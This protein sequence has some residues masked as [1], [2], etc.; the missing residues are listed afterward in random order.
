MEQFGLPSV[1]VSATD[2]VAHLSAR[3]GRY[4]ALPGGE[5]TA[6]VFKLV[7]ADLRADLRALVHAARQQ[8]QATRSA[9]IEVTLEGAAR[10]V[11]LHARPVTEPGWEGL[12][13]VLFEEHAARDEA[14][15]AASPAAQA[16]GGVEM[17]GDLRET[18]RRLQSI[19]EESES[20][21]ERMAIWNEELQSSNEELRSTTEELETSKEE[22]Q[23]VNEE[24]QTI[25]QENRLRLAE[26][27][28][29]SGDLQNLLT[30]TDIATLFL[31]RELRVMRFTPPATEL[32][33]VRPVD[34]G[35]PLS[36]IR[37]GLDYAELG[38][39]A[40]GVL[41]TLAPSER[42]VEGE[43]RWYLAR[44]LPYRTPEDH[45]EGVVVT[46]LDIT[47]RK[48]ADRAVRE[49]E[50]RFRTLAETVPDAVF[51]ATADGAVDYVNGAY[52]VLTGIDGDEVLGTVAW[53]GL[54]HPEDRDAA[55]AAWG[56][57]LAERAPFEAR[58]RLR[59]TASG[60][61]GYRW[62]I[63]RAR[64]VLDD[65]GAPA[66]WFGAITDVDALARA[67]GALRTLAGTLEER[68][69]TRTRQVRQLSSSLVEAERDERRRIA[70]VLH[71]NLQQLL[72]SIQLKVDSTRE[73]SGDAEAVEAQLA[74]VTAWLLESI[75]LTRTLTSDLAPLALS[76]EGV[77]AELAEHMREFHGLQV[78]VVAEGRVPELGRDVGL[79]AARALRELLFNVARHAGTDQATVHVRSSEDRLGV[80]VAD[81]GLGF[82][83]DE[84]GALV[85]GTGLGL[86]GLRE[87]VE[88]FGG[89]MAIESAPG[90]GTR[91][92]ISVPLP[93]A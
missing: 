72:N 23:S 66:R 1:L 51:T 78:E 91:V 79:M 53:P 30:S 14:D 84:A 8:Q 63:V 80:T 54:I 76:G 32:L 18:K 52:G 62:V 12:V 4:F 17:A 44:V 27:K 25:S 40:E 93:S 41:R 60:T 92:T 13:L 10:L 7:R 56:T 47:D 36:E 68:V 2:K 24:L 75:E 38:E 19:I 74:Q 15:G 90:E 26:L 61:D 35:R 67:E 43:G 22:L 89:E 65:R 49:S 86:L 5:L 28:Q 34:R 45:V 21:R 55:A 70:L 88:H 85:R 29:L 37:H 6:S 59:D 20:G 48:R 57:A 50:V 58:Y 16:A 81:E 33:H 11:A 64:P 87:Q 69:A 71:D 42:E 77:L 82:D 9:P 39:D 83:V 73:A 46:F 31:D 3:A